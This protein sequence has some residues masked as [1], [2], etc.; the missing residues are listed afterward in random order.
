MHAVSGSQIYITVYISMTGHK[1][2]AGRDV[3]PLRVP[4][5]PRPR[6]QHAYRVEVQRAA[7]PGLQPHQARL[8]LWLRGPRHRGG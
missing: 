7:A 5:E 2:P 3:C 4:R 1:E 8:R 6:P